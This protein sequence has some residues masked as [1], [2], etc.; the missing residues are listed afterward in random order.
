MIQIYKRNALTIYKLKA[1][2]L[3]HQ[4]A[5]IYK[6]IDIQAKTLTAILKGILKI[7]VI[8]KIILQLNQ[9]IKNHHH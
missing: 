6:I 5:N 9:E 7:A 1:I 8:H 2:T 4:V 3:F